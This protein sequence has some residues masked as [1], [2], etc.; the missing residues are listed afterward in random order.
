MEFWEMWPPEEHERLIENMS[1]W[2][3]GELPDIASTPEAGGPDDLELEVAEHQ[4]CCPSCRD[5]FEELKELRAGF[6]TLPEPDP[7]EGFAQGVLD[8]IREEARPKVIPLFKRPQVRA[9]A[10]LAAC[11]VLVAGLYGVSRRQEQDKW[12]LTVRSFNRDVVE[13]YAD[14]SAQ[15]SL[16]SDGDGPRVNAALADPDKITVVQ[17]APAV[18]TAWGEYFGLSREEATIERM[19]ACLRR[20]GFDY[21]FDTNFSADLTIMEEGNEFLH[22]LKSGGLTRWP[23][24]TS[25]CPGWVRFLKGQYPELTGQLSTS[26]S[27]Q[28]MFGSVTKS[29]F[30]KKLGVE[31]EQICCVSIMPCV[32]KKAE[33]ELPSMTTGHG[34][35][36]DMVLTTRELVRM[37]RADQISPASMPE[38]ALDS[39][40]GTHTGA[41]A[42]FGATGGVMEAALRTAS[43]VLTGENP[44][45]D[46]F[47]AVRTGPGLREVTYE[48]ADIPVRCAVVSGLGNA[49]QLIEQLK[50]GKVHYDF[51]EVMACPGGCVGGGGQPISVED[52]ERYGVR[53]ERLYHLDKANPMRFSHE[54]PDVQT[55][56]EEFLGQ[57]LS[58]KAEELLHTDHTAWNMPSQ[59]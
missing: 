23:M 55:L 24:F 41:G 17:V 16:R 40:L 45:P 9:L 3:D 49:R 2:M 44:D 47:A 7:P 22:R 38:E 1:A 59:A 13:E 34:P 54:N 56:Y 15:E 21:V 4:A 12:M 20:L 43:Y 18:R 19:A 27:P 14:I 37:L 26:K 58:E 50:A 57:P 10:G 25:C 8:R 29:W 42:I 11:L 35:D 28:Q 36:V 51:V 5:L 52:E 33:C 48:I 53:G 46:A 6:E 39:P 31:P 32:A 30:A